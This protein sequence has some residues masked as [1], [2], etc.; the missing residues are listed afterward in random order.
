MF[1]ERPKIV[2][3]TSRIS[4]RIAQ[5]SALYTAPKC[6]KISSVAVL[7]TAKSCVNTE[8]IEFDITLS[9]T[10]CVRAT[11]YSDSIDAE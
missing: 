6:V 3:Y 1:Y 8:N 4:Y 10:A 2:S 7:R 9:I 5:Y 11:R